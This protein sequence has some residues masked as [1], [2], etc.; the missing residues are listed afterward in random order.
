MLK[1]CEKIGKTVRLWHTGDL[2]PESINWLQFTINALYWVGLLVTWAYVKESNRRTREVLDQTVRTFSGGAKNNCKYFGTS[3]DISSERT[4][5][6]STVDGDNDQRYAREFIEIF[7]NN[8]RML[9]LAARKLIGD[10]HAAEDTVQNAFADLWLRRS[11]GQIIKNPIGFVYGTIV[12][13]ALDAF[14]KRVQEN[15]RFL[16]NTECEDMPSRESVLEVDEQIEYLRMALAKMKRQQ[17]EILDLCCVD[18]KACCEVAEMLGKPLGTVHVELWRAKRQVRRLIRIQE[19]LNE[20]Q[21]NKHRG[22]PG[23]GLANPS[24]A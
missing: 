3:G 17:V 6:T 7:R 10:H 8:R 20:A 23:A 22:I 14:D 24:G 12:H 15:R 19:K 13:K 4:N 11:S 21:K 9:Y 18:K 2:D 5:M 16:R 1:D